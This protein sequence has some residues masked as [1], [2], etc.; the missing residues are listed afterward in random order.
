MDPSEN[1][2]AEEATFFKDQE[3]A[4]SFMEFMTSKSTVWKDIIIEMKQ[5]YCT[6]AQHKEYGVLEVD[7]PTL[8]EINNSV[9]K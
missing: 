4:V 2:K 7:F 1:F 3:D 8:D 6:I 9:N 5:L